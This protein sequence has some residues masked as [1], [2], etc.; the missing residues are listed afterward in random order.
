VPC[1]PAIATKR[2]NRMTLIR[3][4]AG[5]TFLSLHRLLPVTRGTLSGS[6]LRLHE[7]VRCRT[8]ILPPC[9][10]VRRG[11]SFCLCLGSVLVLGDLPEHPGHERQQLVE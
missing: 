4:R 3:H 7:M 2:H 6:W 9:L 1:L 8:A 5:H 10:V 11:E